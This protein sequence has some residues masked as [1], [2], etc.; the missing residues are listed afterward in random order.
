MR[1]KDLLTALNIK[2]LRVIARS[3]RASS[4][5]HTA[6]C[7]MARRWRRTGSR[8]SGGIERAARPRVGR[9]FKL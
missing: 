6:V 8:I 1:G 4:T 7:S 5:K 9:R 2:A 3:A